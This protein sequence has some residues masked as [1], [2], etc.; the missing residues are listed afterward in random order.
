MCG[1]IPKTEGAL[2]DVEFIQPQQDFRSIARLRSGPLDLLRS[3]CLNRC[4]FRLMDIF[5]VDALDQ[6]LLEVDD[7]RLWRVFKI[8]GGRKSTS[9]HGHI[10]TG[11]DRPEILQRN[12]LEGYRGPK[13]DIRLRKKIR[14]SIE[15]DLTHVKHNAIEVNLGRIYVVRRFDIPNVLGLKIH[16]RKLKRT[17]WALIRVRHIHILYPKQVYLQGINRFQGLLPPALLDR[18]LLFYLRPCLSKVDVQSR[19]LKQEVRDE[20]AMPQRSPVNTGVQTGHVHDRRIGVLMLYDS[21]I[22]QV[23]RKAYRMEAYCTNTGSVAFETPVDVTLNGS[24]EDVVNIERN[25]RDENS[26]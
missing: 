25:P 23:E 26:Q 21:G 8:G 15:G 6:D 19:S 12:P 2:E 4:C 14:L 9:P 16:M 24:A 11:R 20:S 3:C 17:E 10:V 5:N 1:F 18:G 7:L 22:Q 13:T